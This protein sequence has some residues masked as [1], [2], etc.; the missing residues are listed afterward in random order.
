MTRPPPSRLLL[1]RHPETDWNKE[2]RWQGHADQPLNATGIGQMLASLEAIRAEGVAAIYTSDLLRAQEMAVWLGIKLG[3]RPRVAASL[4][5]RSMGEWEGLTPAEVRARW[6]LEFARAEA[7]PLRVSP[8]GGES[9]AALLRRAA[10]P[11]A[12]IASQHPGETA[13]VA[14]HGGILKALLCTLLDMDLAERETLGLHNGSRVLLEVAPG[15]IPPA[16]QGP[17]ALGRWTILK[18]TQ[19]A[20]RQSTHEI[21]EALL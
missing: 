12:R 13:L 21:D 8:P 19:L 5:E 17:G 1:V 15:R 11:L 6:P 10:P 18:P 9:F 4:R 2:G 7:D 16:R 20:E 3:L 14:T